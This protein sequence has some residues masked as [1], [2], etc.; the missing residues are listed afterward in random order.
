MLPQKIL[1]SAAFS[2]CSLELFEQSLFIP[3][4]IHTYQHAFRPTNSGGVRGV[5]VVVVGYR[6]RELSLNLFEFYIVFGTKLSPTILPLAMA[7]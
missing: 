4:H 2:G 1:S 3:T 7:K 6:H 5:T